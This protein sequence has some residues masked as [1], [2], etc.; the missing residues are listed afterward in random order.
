M[1]IVCSLVAMFIYHL[2]VYVY[3]FM[4]I[5]LY[6]ILYCEYDFNDNNAYGA[7]GNEAV[8]AFSQ[9]ASRLATLTCRPKSAVLRDIYGSMTQLRLYT[10]VY[11]SIVEQRDRMWNAPL[12]GCFE[13]DIRLLIRT[14]SNITVFWYLGS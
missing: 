11:L 3:L 12:H 1:Y 8:E 10:H 7:W 9:L 13:L 4:S 2:S 5:Y 6:G 14:H